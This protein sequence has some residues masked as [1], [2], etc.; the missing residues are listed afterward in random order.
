MFK[1]GLLMEDA[2]FIAEI[3]ANPTDHMARLV[4]ADWLE[5]QGDLRAE[6][7]RLDVELVS[8]SGTSND[9]QDT[10]ERVAIRS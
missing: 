3:Q 2:E 10:M 7:V 1:T 9:L 5:D 8:G 4:Y 6:Y